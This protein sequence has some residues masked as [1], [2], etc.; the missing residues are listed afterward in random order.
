M[1]YLLLLAAMAFSA[2]AEVVNVQDGQGFYVN[3]TNSGTYL[4]GDPLPAEDVHSVIFYMYPVQQVDLTRANYTSQ[5]ELYGGCRSVQLFTT[6]LVSGVEYKMHLVT[7]TEAGDSGL[8]EASVD[9][10]LMR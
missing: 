2:Q 3:C 4:N 9:T 6:N 7:T 10:F 8:S 1:R 5:H